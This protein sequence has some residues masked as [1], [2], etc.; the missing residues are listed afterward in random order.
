[1]LTPIVSKL[2]PVRFLYNAE[3]VLF[4]LISSTP[5][6]TRS[7]AVAK[8]ADRTPYGIAAVCCLDSEVAMGSIA[9]SAPNVYFSVWLDHFRSVPGFLAVV[10][11]I[12]SR[13][14]LRDVDT[15]QPLFNNTVNNDSSIVMFSCQ[16][17]VKKFTRYATIHLHRSCQKNAT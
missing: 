11:W 9:I 4:T 5:I 8:K 15:T 2:S 1:M 17:N 10:M 3:C 6:T 14:L 12:P 16:K 7:P 13:S